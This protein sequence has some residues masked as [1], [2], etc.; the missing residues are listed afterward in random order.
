VN[1]SAGRSND[2]ADG[3]RRWW[4]VTGLVGLVLAVFS[5][6]FYAYATFGGQNKGRVEL[7]F[8]S[9]GTFYA[10]DESGD[11][12]EAPR[13]E[14]KPAGG[15]AVTYNIPMGYYRSRLT[16]SLIKVNGPATVTCFGKELF[17]LRGIQAWAAWINYQN[18]LALLGIVLAVVARDRLRRQRKPG[19]AI[20]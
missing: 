14:V 15:E 17:V 10:V 16:G 2:S 20:R 4:I 9:P 5:L 12:T 11:R 8:E 19:Q 18:L 7:L 3:Q 13:C 1:A 6:G